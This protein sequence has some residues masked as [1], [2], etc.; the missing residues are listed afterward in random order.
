MIFL[1]VLLRKIYLQFDIKV[2]MIIKSKGVILFLLIISL[3]YLLAKSKI[4]KSLLRS[5]HFFAHV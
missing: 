3:F 4:S 1:T 2:H 5:F